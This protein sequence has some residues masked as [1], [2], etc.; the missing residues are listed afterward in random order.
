MSN[1]QDVKPR[2][3]HIVI[4]NPDQWRGDVMG[5][6]GHPAA[7]T[8]NLDR[9]VQTDAVSFA[10]AFSQN[11][12]CTASRCS[13]MT[14]W[15][16]HVAGHRTMS[17]MLRPHEPM[18]LRTLKQHGYH[19]WW[20]GKNDVIPT[21]NGF[22]D[23]CD[24]KF[25]PPAEEANKTPARPAENWRGDPQGDNYFSFYM[26]RLE[27]GDALAG[28][29]TGGDWAMVRGAV[30]LIR[31]YEGD[32]PLCIY[33]AL[34]YPH[35]PYAAEEPWFSMI[36]R[37]KV[38]PR[39]PIP[40]DASLEPAMYRQMRDKLRMGDWTDERWQ[41]LRATYIASCAQVDH[42]FGMVVDALK[43][44][45]R[46][47][48]TA[49]FF[50]SDHGDLTGDYDVVQKADGIFPDCQMHVPLIVKPPA[51]TPVK[52]RVTDALAELVDFPATVEALTGAGPYH[53]HF[54]RS[55][56]PVIAGETDQHR[57][58]VFGEGGRLYGSIAA[59]SREL[60]PEPFEECQYWPT[61]RLYRM[62]TPS[63]G[64]AVMLR[65]AEYKYVQRLYDVEELYDLRCDPQE[66]D[67][68]INDP[69]YAEVLNRLRQ[70]MLRFHL[71]TS[72]VVPRDVNAR[73]ARETDFERIR[74]FNAE[75]A[76]RACPIDAFIEEVEDPTRE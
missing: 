1:Q 7:V 17:H 74:R 27:G 15:Y 57:D 48:E 20:G 76:T 32:K 45:E 3:P 37:S 46:Y 60:V 42:Q 67:N 54:G 35:P 23:Y 69:D 6:M 53:D 41:E 36:D 19:V 75:Y 13:F 22:D 2:P 10:N 58:A 47:D 34:N 11:I 38:P 12:C 59:Q 66:V 70:R 64:K 8:P 31:N 39:A 18:L 51:N 24:V 28:E 62:D 30:D 49:L 43:E 29:T 65:T 50:F 56:L 55:L 4:F 52:P 25:V 61:L 71:E 9:L 16:P 14:G 68:R 40:A 63:I 72:D 73:T 26:G 33:M 5:H 21:E 44:T